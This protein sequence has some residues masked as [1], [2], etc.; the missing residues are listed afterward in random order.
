MNIFLPTL[1]FC[2]VIYIFYTEL[3]H[4]EEEEEE[5]AL[6]AP[7]E[8]AP[9][10]PPAVE[11][12][13]EEVKLVSPPNIKVPPR[14]VS[15][16][17]AVVTTPVATAR[18]PPSPVQVAPPSP[19]QVA[20][21]APVQV[22]PPVV[23]VAPSTEQRS[24]LKVETTRLNMDRNGS[25]ASRAPLGINVKKVTPVMLEVL[26]PVGEDEQKPQKS[27]ESSK[28]IESTATVELKKR[29]ETKANEKFVSQVTMS[30][31]SNAKPNLPSA[32]QLV[33]SD[34]INKESD[35][36][37]TGTK[38]TPS[39]KSDSLV[40][41][42]TLSLNKP[43]S[44]AAA[45]AGGQAPNAPSWKSPLRTGVVSVK[46]SPFKQSEAAGK[47]VT[48]YVKDQKSNTPRQ[49]GSSPFAVSYLKS[50]SPVSQV[51]ASLKS[52]SAP[53]GPEESRKQ[54]GRK[55]NKLTPATWLQKPNESSV[56]AKKGSHV[57]ATTKPESSAGKGVNSRFAQMQQKFSGASSTAAPKDQS[58]GSV[59]SVT[60]TQLK[61]DLSVPHT[62]EKRPVSKSSID[63]SLK[64]TRTAQLN[65][66]T[67]ETVTVVPQ[68]TKSS[69]VVQVTD[70]TAALVVEPHKKGQSISLVIN[71]DNHEDPISVIPSV[72]PPCVSTTRTSK[73]EQD[74]VSVNKS[75]SPG[76]ISEAPLSSK[77]NGTMMELNNNTYVQSQPR[78]TSLPKSTEPPQFVRR[79]E[80]QAVMDGDQVEFVVEIIGMS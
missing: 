66:S 19:V 25:A 37:L 35:V 13:P 71:N 62:N 50:N 63:T 32:F 33:P 58:F 31:N 1:V 57:V 28:T 9:V 70:N 47:P 51:T 46:E 59:Y 38:V 34:N 16:P 68:L 40:Y 78:K 39:Q 76:A 72:A 65:G 64:T 69:L 3:A 42:M 53:T 15:S 17:A 77:T 41:Q 45:P 55:V 75:A 5:P 8:V 43:K 30:V 10:S 12:P 24:K 18:S 56:S 20:P 61:S 11:K 14:K 74:V 23:K 67:E 26:H 27:G 79:L 36:M 60:K 54:T 44:A 52:N 29:N 49:K 21:R 48:S 22:P 4:S 2:Q 73:T 7:P 6:V 80:D